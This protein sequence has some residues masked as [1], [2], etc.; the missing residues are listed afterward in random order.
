[1]TPLGRLELGRAVALR[2]AN[3]FVVEAAEGG[4]AKRLHLRNTGRLLDLVYPGAVLL[5]QP[6][7]GHR[8]SGVVVGVEV[9]GGLAAL[10]DPRLQARFLEEAWAR[11]LV[12]WLEGWR[13]VGREAYYRGSRIDYLLEGPVGL[14][15]LMEVKSAVFLSGDRLCMY[16]DTVSLR[17]RRHVE[18]LIDARGEG[19]RAILVFISAHPLCEGFRP[20]CEVDP[21]LCGLLER[22]CEAGVEV[23]AVKM[24]LDGGGGVFLDTV[25]L[26]VRLDG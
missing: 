1:V 5:Y 12:G 24:H 18:R 11:G 26:P 23:R 10:I 14:R 7:A 21:R 3:R 2:R 17:G 15:G 25:D 9:A 8:T 19:Y 13:A 20:C 22:A 4:V 16:P 6:G